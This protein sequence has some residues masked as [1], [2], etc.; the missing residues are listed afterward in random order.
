MKSATRSVS[1]PLQGKYRTAVALA[2]AG[3]LS[4][5]AI[6][7]TSTAI[8]EEIVVTAER[9]AINLQD[10]PASATV[11]TADTLAS[12]G[13]DNIIEIQQVAPSVSIN[14][15]NRGTFINI[16]GVGIAQSAPTSNPGVAYYVDGVFIPHETFIS[17]S[18]YDIESIEVLRGPQGTLTGQNSTGGAVYVRTPAPNFDG[19]SG[20]IDQTAGQ[21]DW[22]RTVGAV[23]IPMGSVF[24][25]RVAAVYE[26]RGSYTDN[27][28]PSPSEPGSSNLRSARAAVRFKPNDSMTF[29]LR[30]EYFDLDS[31]YNAVKRRGDTVSLDP[32]VIQED[33]LSFLDQEGY[34]TSLETRIDLG[35]SVQ[36]RNLTSY[37]NGENYDQADG[38]RSA[39]APPGP[40]QGGRVGFTAQAF[41]TLITEINLLSIG[42]GNFQWV[43]G[44]FYLD[45]TTPVSVLRDNTRTNTYQTPSSRTVAEAENTS[46]SVFGQVD[47]R[48]NDAFAIDLGLRYSE[49]QQDYL[50]I[51]VPGPNPGLGCYP[52]SGTAESSKTTG[53]LSGK[54][55][56]NDDTMLYL[57]ASR[58][59]KA[60][61]VNLTPGLAN[62]APETNNVAELGVKTTVADGRLRINGDVFYSIY[63]GI[64]LSALLNGL[65]NTLNAAES[66][67]YGAEL[68]VTGQFGGLGT[69]FGLSY[70]HGEFSED[71]ILTDNSEIPS[72]N[73][74]VLNGTP[75]PF[76]PKI[77]ASAGIQYDFNVG[78]MVLTPRVQATHMAKQ[79]A[80]SF[81]GPNTTV[82]SRTVADVRITL[83]IMESLKLEGFVT[84]VTDKTYIAVQVQ[85][86]SS[87]SGGY[88]YG[89]PRQAGARIKYSF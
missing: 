83:A 30:Y 49:D 62:F 76:S 65:P 6:A 9:R 13:I 5:A 20:Y 41:E 75:L 68:E 86:A 17:Q 43:A 44:A 48:F 80:T 59:Y 55:N 8:L 21:Y 24:A 66:T 46:A 73:K 63:D 37:L 38:D 28:G 16:R 45:E 54:Y 57:T 85:E 81:P 61:G 74:P 29:D 88:I 70:L 11:L 27:I 89:A 36:F 25:A 42:D 14:S 67:I 53:R 72:V 18:F 2:V 52:C 15:Y 22:Y 47:F 51:A 10:I 60:G 31:D 26:T 19:F 4:N 71:T 23:N 77:T 56:L 1:R 50:R 79:Y 64:Q 35:S 78:N 7:Q 39:T 3:I 84:N 40:G 82:P 34:R 12:Q 69:N 33:A 32:F 58:G 87:A